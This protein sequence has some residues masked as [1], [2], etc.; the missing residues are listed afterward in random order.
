MKSNTFLATMA[1][2]LGLAALAS[3]AAPPTAEQSDKMKQAM[4]TEPPAK[5]TQPRKMLLFSLT[6][7]FRHSSIECGIE[8]LRMMGASTGAFTVDPATNPAVFKADNLKNY[9]GVIFLN[10]TGA[11]FEDAELKQ[12]LLEFVRNGGGVVGIHA[13][14]DCFYTWPEFGRMMG[15]YFDG[16]PW[17]EAV[18]LRV[19]EPEHPC[20][21]CFNGATHYGVTDEIY[22]FKDEPYSRKLLRILTSLD[23]T[24]LDMTRKGIK[25]TDGDF[26]VSWVHT[27]GKGRVFY[28]SLGHREEIYWN[29]T[30]LKHYLAGIQFATGDLKAEAAPRNDPP[31]APKPTPSPSPAPDPALKAYDYGQARAPL[32]AVQEAIRT[33]QGDRARL[34]VI[35][36]QMIE[37][38]K[39]ADA[40]FAAKQFACRELQA[41]GTAKS[42][43]ALAALL[44]DAKT[45]DIARYALERIGGDEA[46]A[47]L[48]AALKAATGPVRIGIVNS[49]GERRDA[50]SVAALT[51]LARDTDAPTADAAIAALGKIGGGDALKALQVAARPPVGV[52]ADALLMCAESLAKRSRSDAAGVYR[53]VFENAAASP[54]A[55]KGALRGWM[56]TEP[57]AAEAKLLALLE[58]TDAAAQM[59]AAGLIRD[60]PAERPLAP[61]AERLPKLGP[62]AQVAVIA[63]LAARNDAGAV[64]SVVGMTASADEAVRAAAVEALGWMPGTPEGAVALA[65]VASSSQGDLQKAARASLSRINGAGVD[66]AVL[67]GVAAGETAMRL[68]WIRQAADRRSKGGAKALLALAV[69]GDAAIRTAALKGLEDLGDPSAVGGLAGWLAK[70]A[71]A[72]ERTAAERAVAASARKNPEAAVRALD[73]A[74]TSGSREAKASVLACLAAIGT[75]GALAKVTA[76]AADADEELATAAVRGLSNWPDAAALPELAKLA[77]AGRTPTQ[78]A[79]AL[80]GVL[81]LMDSDGRLLPADRVA[82]L[83]DLA[84]G[85]SADDKKQMLNKLGGLADAKALELATSFAA[86]PALKTEADLAAGQIRKAM[87]GPALVTASHN[88]GAAKLALDGKAETRWDTGTPQVPGMWFLLDQRTSKP[89]AHIVLDS[90]GSGSD[91]PRGWEVYVGDTSSAMDKPVAKGAGKSAV[92]D[93]RLPQP[94]TGRFVKIVQTGAVEGLYWSIHEL[95]VE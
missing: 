7:G 80:R 57:K 24:K 29:P 46:G 56:L 18:T 72:R 47:A 6:R 21:Y 67:A 92:V 79:L 17:H 85:A 77:K 22:Q 66:A 16:H 9:D 94:V 69:D 73:G 14:T 44:A 54:V 88:S 11:L 87:Q 63:A 75:G 71:D 51:A 40:T 91:Y 25:R 42:V 83:A 62:G 50:P 39:A 78:K 2:V 12:G 49:L 81:R 89:V 93:I 5:V 61:V 84:A 76:A 28:C 19:E 15:G 82:M 59:M 58:G 70:A 55:R 3:V 27:F 31:P 34:A 35:E 4:P 33:A 52:M 8:A 37:V 38:L 48:R 53:S 20:N 1:A 64:P 30:I 13:A 86:D 45:A 90:S 10:T 68:E 26:A 74:W 32:T 41:I 65:K 95:K 23:V 36:E 43:P 60:W